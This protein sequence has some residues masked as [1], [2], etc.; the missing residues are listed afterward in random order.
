VEEQNQNKDAQDI[1][2]G[3]DGVAPDVPAAPGLPPLPAAPTAGQPVPAQAD[4]NDFGDYGPM[5]APTATAPG[6]PM[7]EAPAPNPMMPQS[8]PMQA[9][10]EM[11]G[12]FEPDQN[13]PSAP[14]N[15]DIEKL[16]QIAESVVNERWEELL[17]KAGN[18]PVWKEKVNMNITAIKQ[19][20]VRISERFDNLQNAVLGKV[21]EYDQGVK[22]IHSEMKAMEKVFERILEPLV[23]NIKELDK[24]T[25][26]MKRK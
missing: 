25:K 11:G 22:N 13:Y 8:A 3:I 18:L 24:I 15:V 26:E 2:A 17:S 6:A 23:S 14:G 9:P 16:H 1:K 10:Q 19:E 21:K 20:L 12:S 7:P 4:S 5:K